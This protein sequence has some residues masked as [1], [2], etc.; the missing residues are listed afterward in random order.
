MIDHVM[1]TVDDTEVVMIEVAMAETT[2]D[3]T[4]VV[5]P[6]ETMIITMA[7]GKCLPQFPFLLPCKT[8]LRSALPYLVLSFP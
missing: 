3:T 2:T 7:A 8:S 4:T 5:L 6:T 1:M